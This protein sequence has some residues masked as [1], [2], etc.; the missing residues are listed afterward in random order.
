MSSS[1]KEASLEGTQWTQ[2]HS[3]ALTGSLWICL[4]NQSHLL[5]ASPACQPTPSPLSEFLLAACIDGGSGLKLFYRDKFL[6]LLGQ[7]VC[8]MFPL[9]S[10]LFAK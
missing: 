10:C 2:V 8:F 5:E 7:G 9:Y 6:I 1:V 4:Q 3:F